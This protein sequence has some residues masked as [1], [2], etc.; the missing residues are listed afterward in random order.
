M[1]FILFEA[2]IALTGVLLGIAFAI[3]RQKKK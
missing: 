3:Y 2:Y 1:D